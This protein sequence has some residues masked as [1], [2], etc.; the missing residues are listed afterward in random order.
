MNQ[1]NYL[2]P[3]NINNSRVLNTT[4]VISLV[5]VII[6]LIS[7][8]LFDPVKNKGINSALIYASYAIAIFLM[9]S[10]IRAH[11]E[12]DLGG[13]M[14]YG[15]G[16][17][18]AL[19]VGLIVSLIIFLFYFLLYKIIDPSLLKEISNVS[20]AEMEKN[21]AN[22]QEIEFSKSIL[23]DPFWISFGLSIINL[24]SFI[25]F[26]LIISAFL[27]KWPRPANTYVASNLNLDDNRNEL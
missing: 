3:L 4:L 22:E 16:L 11:R 1:I 10:N 17:L 13:Y 26:G 7:N 21:G 12:I 5:L 9:I 6:A 24:I 19:F 18:F 2:P 8:L 27:Y 23:K 15:R 25:F 14:P 20:L